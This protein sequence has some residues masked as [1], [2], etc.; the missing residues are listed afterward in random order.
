MEKY[1][2]PQEIMWQIYYLHILST[3]T[4]IS[5]YVH[6]YIKYGIYVYIC[7]YVYIHVYIYGHR[8]RC[9]YICMYIHI[10]V[11]DF[12]ILRKEHLKNKMKSFC[13]VSIEWNKI[14]VKNETSWDWRDGSEVKNIECSSRGHAFNPQQPHGGSQPTVMGS[15]ALLWCASIHTSRTLYNRYVGR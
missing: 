5:I 6:I 12:I 4:P 1:K 13:K 15:D 2:W 8:C 11:C 7:I 9:R 10:C 14:Y 3:S